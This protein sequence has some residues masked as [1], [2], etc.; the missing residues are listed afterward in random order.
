MDLVYQHKVQYYETDQM[1]V[2]HHSNYIR[3]FEESRTDFLEKSGFSYAWME[4]QGIIIPVL[5]VSA[6]YKMMVH[7]GEEVLIFPTVTE[8]NGVK[9]ALSY[10]VIKA[11][12]GE[13]ATTGKSS[14]C[15]LDRAYRPL[16]LKKEFPQVYEM[17][18]SCLSHG[19]KEIPPSAR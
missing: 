18:M 2:V 5:S 17:F 9:M 10:Q 16:R 13:L 4:E 8:F 11:M 3:W 19:Q 6:E 12:T 7:Y 15:F 1:K 14:H